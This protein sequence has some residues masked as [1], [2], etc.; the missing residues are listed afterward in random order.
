MKTLTLTLALFLFLSPY[1]QITTTK[2]VDAPKSEKKL[3]DSTEN[4]LG[5]NV[6]QYIGQDLY[7]KGISEGL[8][9]MGYTYF[10][11]DYTKSKFDKENIYKAE[12]LGSKYED[13]AGKYFTVLDVIKNAK[14]DNEYFLK[15]QEKE[16]KDIVYY[17]YSSEFKY[18]FPFVVSGYFIKYKKECIGKK[19]IVKGKNWMQ[20]KTKPMLNIKTGEP[21][22]EFEPG[23]VWQVVDL[24]IEEK[25]YNLSL[26][27]EN[28]RHEQIPLP[29]HDLDFNFRLKNKTSLYHA[30]SN[31]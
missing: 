30:S 14:R 3:Y 27:L 5:D 25:Y 16:S 10:I 29:V 21:V 23:S 15:L 6:K 22:S 17:V 2:V 4:F 12:G 28:A 1:C 7:L 20:G 24:T 13:L 19:Y 8:R 26:I 9:G 18:S 31:Q 11:L